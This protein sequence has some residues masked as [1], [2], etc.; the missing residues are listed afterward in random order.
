MAS[1]LAPIGKR[2]GRPDSPHV[3]RVERLQGGCRGPV[4]CRQAR[5]SLRHDV[6]RSAV[7]PD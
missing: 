7:R 2:A 6:I 1:R 4:A 5:I 3:D